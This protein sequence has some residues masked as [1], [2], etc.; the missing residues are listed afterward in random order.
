MPRFASHHTV[1]PNGETGPRN[2]DRGGR[3]SRCR[4][5]VKHSPAMSSTLVQAAPALS[6][7]SRSRARPAVL[8]PAHLRTRRANRRAP[9]P[10]LGLQVG[11]RAARRGQSGGNAC[12][13][14]GPRVSR[15]RVVAGFCVGAK[16]KAT[17]LSSGIVDMGARV[18]NPYTGTFAEPDPIEHG[19]ASAYGYANGDPV[20]NTDLTGKG[21][22]AECVSGSGYHP[23]STCYSDSGL[24]ALA[25]VGSIL[26]TVG[27]CAAAGFAP[28]V[29]ALVA[30]AAF[31]VA[32]DANS[33][34]STSTKA[35][36]IALDIVGAAGDGVFAGADKL[37]EAAPAAIRV[38]QK[39][40]H[41]GADAVLAEAAARRR[42]R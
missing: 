29:G 33:H 1:S 38:S 7:P 37:M 28:C 30:N 5:L 42:R 17:E 18:Y 22:V 2:P 27:V 9:E 10:H 26:S 23:P 15:A 35:G 12:T 41:T 31:G 36:E 40:I 34:A 13:H 32:Q 16:E 39:V 3:Q 24:G 19:G 8:D 20:N 14:P 25:R 4:R 11:W 21:G 6:S